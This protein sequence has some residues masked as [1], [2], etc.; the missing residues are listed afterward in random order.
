M[1][2]LIGIAIVI[3]SLLGA[4]FILGISPAKLGQPAE[5]VIIMGFGIGAFIIANTR[6]VIAKVIGGVAAAIRGP[7]HSK[8]DFLEL[9]SLLYQTFKLAKSKGMLALEGHVE[10]PDDSNLFAQFPGFSKDRD[11]R[12]FLCDYLRL[13]TLGTDN[14]HEVEALIDEELHAHHEE[15]LM[16]PKAIQV[17]GDAMPALG[18]CAAVMGVIHTMEIVATGGGVEEIGVAIGA[19]LVG[20]FL[21]VFLGYALFSPLAAAIQTVYDAE[22]RYYHCIKGGLLAYMQGY[23]PAVCVEFARKTLSHGVRP[24]FYEVEEATQGLPPV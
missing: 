4:M 10:H 5:F 3:V 9:L 19:A 2:L 12:D 22:T 7:K 11:A 21:G 23:A 8:E 20:T 16:L 1:I 18:I 15:K 17:L 6:S 13:L 14:P 24:T